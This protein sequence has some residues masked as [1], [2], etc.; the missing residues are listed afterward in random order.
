[1]ASDILQ[2][3]IRSHSYYVVVNIWHLL[4]S[5]LTTFLIFFPIAVLTIPHCIHILLNLV[6]SKHLH[7]V[8]FSPPTGAQ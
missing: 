3:K 6:L 7:K 5:I 2:N 1:M 8:S 4:T